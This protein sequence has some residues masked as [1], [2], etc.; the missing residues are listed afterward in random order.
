MLNFS[1]LKRIWCVER[2]LK[3][4]GFRIQFAL[5]QKSVTC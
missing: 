5:K 4:Y 3:T 2:F 1:V